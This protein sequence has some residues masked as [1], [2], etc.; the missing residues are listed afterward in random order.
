MWKLQTVVIHKPIDFII[1]KEYAEHFV[2]DHKYYRETSDSFRFRNIPK[3]KFSEFRSKPISDKI[4]LIY[5][6]LK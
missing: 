6:K 5:G 4:T 3:Q 1:A 2:G